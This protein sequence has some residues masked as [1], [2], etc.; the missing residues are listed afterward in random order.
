M[1]LPRVNRDRPDPDQAARLSRWLKEWE[2]LQAL[3]PDAPP[4]ASHTPLALADAA[5]PAPVQAGDIRLLHPAIEPHGV[6]YIAVLCQ[7]NGGDFLVAPFGLLS[8]PAT[9]GEVATGRTT[10]ALRVLCIW[11]RFE[12]CRANLQRSWL[13]DRL[14]DEECHTLLAP[15]VTASAMG[16]A[17][18]PADR[19]G[20]PLRHPLDPRWDYL[21]M[22]SEFRQRACRPTRQG[23]VY[24]IGVG[25]RRQA[26]ETHTPYETPA[27]KDE[28]G[29]EDRGTP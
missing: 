19:T 18:W 13:A 10:P 6:R 4:P 23:V 3:A 7:Q 26:A 15:M 21:D 9:P 24:D 11:N 17:T 16:A 25:E 27:G 2:L 5:D 14:N 20:P 29:D 8:E 1:T 28:D 12:M 22:E